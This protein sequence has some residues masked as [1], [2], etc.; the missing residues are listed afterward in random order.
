MVQTH[1]YNTAEADVFSPPFSFF[2]PLLLFPKIPNQIL[3]LPAGFYAS[4]KW[5]DCQTDKHAISQSGEGKKKIQPLSHPASYHKGTF[6][7]PVKKSK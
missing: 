5:C 2:F 7:K 4:H 1:Q 6:N 3:W